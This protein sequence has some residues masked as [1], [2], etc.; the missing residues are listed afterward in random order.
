MSAN[1]RS[2][3]RRANSDELSRKVSYGGP[4]LYLQLMDKQLII[5][6]KT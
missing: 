4:L 6:T 5:K 3:R 2:L 1:K